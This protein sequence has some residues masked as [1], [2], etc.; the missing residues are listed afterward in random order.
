MTKIHALYQTQKNL[1]G[2]FKYTRHTVISFMKNI[3]D[4]GCCKS[5]WRLMD[6]WWIISQGCI[7]AVVL[8]V[9]SLYKQMVEKPDTVYIYHAADICLG[10]ICQAEVS[11]KS[12]HHYNMN[13]LYSPRHLLYNHRKHCTAK[14]PLIFIGEPTIIHHWMKNY[15]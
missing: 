1:L 4:D 2:Y 10:K 8:D 15:S 12:T 9:L 6:V 7:H 14:Y 13:L 11:H 3:Q 5:I